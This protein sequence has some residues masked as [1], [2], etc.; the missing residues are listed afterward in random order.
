MP[1]LAFTALKPTYR[2]RVAL[3]WST[4]AFVDAG[5]AGVVDVGHAAGGDAAGGVVAVTGLVVEV[6]VGAECA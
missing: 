2:G 3:R 1:P 5:A 4:I 6:H